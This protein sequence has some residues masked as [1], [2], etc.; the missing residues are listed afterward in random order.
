MQERQ[1]KWIDPVTFKHGTNI[2]KM[3]LIDKVTE[4]TYKKK[5]REEK[6]RK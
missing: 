3:E 6:Q 5:Q 4:I 1:R 2:K